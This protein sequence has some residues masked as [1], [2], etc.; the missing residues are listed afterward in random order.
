VAE[1]VPLG[2]HGHKPLGIAPSL[3]H[4][5]PLIR[6]LQAL[7]HLRECPSTASEVAHVLGV[8]RSTASRLLQELEAAGYV[9]RDPSGRRFVA[10]PDKFGPG[11]L[12]ARLKEGHRA[13]DS[14]WGEVMH[15]ELRRLRDE[16][17]ESTM[18]AV[19][20]RDRMLYA[21]FFGTDHPIG[22]QESLGSARPMH[23]SAVGKAYLSALP[24]ALLDVV[25]GR[26]DYS[27]GT[28]RAARGPFQLRDMLDEVREKH[29]AVDHDETFVGLSCV[30][31]PVIVDGSTLVG[32]AGVTGLTQRF[33]QERVEAFGAVL[34]ER[35]HNL[36]GR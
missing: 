11:R 3:R 8:N 16:L 5:S 14:S 33:N 22:V 25:L 34:V 7:D 6:G 1:A 21:A 35:L 2:A 13:Y 24:S 29:Y 10:A 19:P 36:E 15:R 17:G 31:T 12:V 18:F 32:A 26:L 4:R 30:A 23:A 27:G 9:M 28:E 20:A